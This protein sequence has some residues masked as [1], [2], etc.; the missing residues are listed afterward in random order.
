MII[1]QKSFFVPFCRK[2][3][4]SRKM[5]VFRPECN[6]KKREKLYFHTPWLILVSPFTSWLLVVKLLRIDFCKMP[7]SC[8]SG[9]DTVSIFLKDF[10]EKF[11]FRIRRE[12]AVFCPFFPTSKPFSFQVTFALKCYCNQLKNKAL[13]ISQPFKS[14]LMGCEASQ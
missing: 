10:K 8:D 9:E 11:C 13:K 14:L 6:G 5:I 12:K 2:K 4:I 7:L 3:C 1:I